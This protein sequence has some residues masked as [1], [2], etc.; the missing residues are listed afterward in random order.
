MTP[1]AA[2]AQWNPAACSGWNKTLH[3]VHSS[4]GPESGDASAPRGEERRRRGRSRETAAMPGGWWQNRQSRWKGR[5]QDANQKPPTA[6]A[7]S[8][9]PV[10]FCLPRLSPVSLPTFPQGGGWERAG[11]G[12]QEGFWTSHRHQPPAMSHG[13]AAS[14]RSN[15]EPARMR[16]EALPRGSSGRPAVPENGSRRATADATP[17]GGKCGG[18]K[19]LKRPGCVPWPLWI[20]GKTTW[21]FA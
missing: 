16:P 8:S 14:R 7:P 10:T 21:E 9:L 12:R 3:H 6:V 11:S 2:G 15:Q 19:E 1:K 5:L 18:N 4:Q 13:D 17:R 20:G